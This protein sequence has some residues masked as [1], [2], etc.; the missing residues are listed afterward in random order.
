MPKSHSRGRTELDT[1]GSRLVL[2]L[3]PASPSSGTSMRPGPWEGVPGEPWDPASLVC[4]CVPWQGGGGG[5]GHPNPMTSPN[6]QKCGYFSLAV[7]PSAIP[8][9]TCPCLKDSTG[10][11][12]SPA[13]HLPLTPPSLLLFL[14]PSF[15][16]CLPYSRRQF[17]RTAASQNLTVERS[18]RPTLCLYRSPCAASSME[19][20]S[21]RW[22]ES[23]RG[24]GYLPRQPLLLLGSSDPK[25][26]PAHS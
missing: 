26:L 9:Y 4:A 8:G 12:F 1:Q 14:P 10:A 16:P 5:L 7:V 20:V 17:L 24:R 15:F 13:R 23:S 22:L 18:P 11:L 21:L 6:K 2:P 25:K 19:I 3:G